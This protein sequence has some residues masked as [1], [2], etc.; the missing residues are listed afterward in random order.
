[1]YFYGIIEQ[2][3]RGFVVHIYFVKDERFME[4][5]SN[6]QYMQIT[7]TTWGDVYNE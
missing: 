5:F 4:D 2:K 6:V 7:E 3:R 1:M